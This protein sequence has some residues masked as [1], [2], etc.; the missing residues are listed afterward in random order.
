MSAP[1]QKKPEDKKA[2]V[3]D[4]RAKVAAW[5]QQAKAGNPSTE[6]PKPNV[7]PQQ[8]P[9][10]RKPPALSGRGRWGRHP[11][12]PSKRHRRRYE[13]DSDSESDQSDSCQKGG[14]A[15]ADVPQGEEGGSDGEYEEESQPA[16]RPA[17]RSRAQPRQAA[18][19]QRGPPAQRA[20]PRPRVP[21]SEVVRAEVQRHHQ[22]LREAEERARLAAQGERT[23][24]ALG[25]LQFF[26]R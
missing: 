13:D 17:G 23:G 8:P 3:E 2:Q 24:S 5:L 15:D 22:E 9:Q 26:A 16:P 18:S 10:Q 19:R 11:P 25:A 21:L 7:A 12:P 4:A 20:P 6:A 1:E 14:A